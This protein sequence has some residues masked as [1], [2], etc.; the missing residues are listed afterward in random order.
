MEQSYINTL[1]EGLNIQA[2]HP[3]HRSAWARDET[4]YNPSKTA[5]V[6][7]F[8]IYERTMTNEMGRIIWGRLT[9]ESV[10]VLGQMQKH[11]VYCWEQPFANWIDDNC[12][13]VKIDNGSESYPLL[14]VDLNKGL[15]KIA[16]TDNL[17]SRA[18]QVR[19]NAISEI[20]S[21]GC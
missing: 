21:Q 16:G 19:K 4:C 2:V 13:V 1:P 17:N 3:H 8:N 18:S 10:H 9:G 7:G 12:F 20:W 15:Q 14:A 5:F 6:A 11:L